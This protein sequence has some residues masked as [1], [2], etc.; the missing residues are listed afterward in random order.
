MAEHQED[1]AAAAA[2]RPEMPETVSVESL[3]EQ[4]VAL[5]TL[6]E[7]R[8]ANLCKALENAHILI[9]YASEHGITVPEECL[10]RIFTAADK[11]AAD[12]WSA[13]Q[14]VAFWTASSQLAQCVAPVTLESITATLFPTRAGSKAGKETRLF[15]IIT[16]LFLAALIAAQIFWV[17]LNNIVSVVHTRRDDLLRDLA[18]IAEI[19]LQNRSGERDFFSL[20]ESSEAVGSSTDA[21]SE[22]KRQEI[23]KK[24]SEIRQHRDKLEQE[25]QKLQGERTQ[26]NQILEANLGILRKLIRYILLEV[27]LVTAQQTTEGTSSPTS[28]NS[29]LFGLSMEDELRV[30]WAEQI[31]QTMSTYFLPMFYGLVGACA[32]ILRS[33]SGSIQ[34]ITFAGASVIQYR[35]R[36][37]L[38]MLSG[39]AVGWFFKQ[40][41]LPS[42]ILQ[43]SRSPLRLSQ[44]TVLSCYFKP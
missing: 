27:S 35:L 26:R 41:T 14:E 43:F 9:R 37:P 12:T 23:E 38:G 13:Q 34:Q 36:L 6:P 10:T 17:I 32:Y 2:G 11:L 1:Q 16:I 22:S 44:A 30:T 25:M 29:K 8:K 7:S 33:L 4:T 39:I 21:H 28:D 20:L 24:I 5:S 19:E 15:S 42:G 3:E 40:D 18:K 31:L